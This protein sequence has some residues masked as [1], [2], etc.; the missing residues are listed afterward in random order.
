MAWLPVMT[1]PDASTIETVLPSSDTVDTDV[2]VHGYRVRRADGQISEFSTLTE[3]A[4]YLHDQF[5]QATYDALVSGSVMEFR[6]S[7]RA[8][9]P[10]RDTALRTAVLDHLQSADDRQ[11][12]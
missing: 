5:D 8:V 9:G 3:V 12:A 10:T 1:L 7:N 11:T 4:T 6:Q 2:T